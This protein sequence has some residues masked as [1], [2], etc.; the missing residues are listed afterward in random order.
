[1]TVEEDSPASVKAKLT[2]AMERVL[3]SCLEGQSAFFPDAI[4]EV[5]ASFVSLKGS[6]VVLLVSRSA[7]SRRKGANRLIGAKGWHGCLTCV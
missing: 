7:E 4:L 5:R 2:A 3:A 6:I 1:M